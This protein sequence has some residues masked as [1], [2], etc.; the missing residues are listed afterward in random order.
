M[1]CYYLLSR[2]TV[3]RDCRIWRKTGHGSVLRMTAAFVADIFAYASVIVSLN[4]RIYVLGLLNTG[5]ADL[6][7]KVRF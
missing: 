7:T 2:W 4:A 6:S 3:E 1:Y 5:L